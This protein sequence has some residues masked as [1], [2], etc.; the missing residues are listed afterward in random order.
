MYAND[1]TTAKKATVR[2]TAFCESKDIF[3]PNEIASSGRFIGSGFFINTDGYILTCH[4]LI[5]DAIKI[6]INTVDDG[7]KSFR[8]DIISVYP[9]ADIAVLHMKNY[10][11]KICLR[12][13][14]SDKAETESDVI[15][16]GYPLGD[17]NIKT[18]KGIISGIKDYLI[19]TD[20]TINNGNSGG[21]LL[22][23]SYEVIGVNILKRVG[24]SMNVIEGIGYCVPIKIFLTV[25]DLMMHHVSS[26][27]SKDVISYDLDNKINVIYRPNFYC[28]FQTLEKKEA[29]LM[30]HIYNKNNNSSEPIEGYIIVFIY[31][32]S[33]LA[34]CDT[35]MTVN[36]IL[37]EF[38]G[39]KI[40]RYGTIN[41]GTNMGRM[42][43][44][45]YIM[46]C[47]HDEMINI[48]FFSVKKQKIMTTHIIFKNEYCYAIPEIQ[49]PTKIKY[50]DNGG[51]IICELTTNHIAELINNS[52]I[53]FVN[54]SLL[55]KYL[56]YSNRDIPTIFISKILPSSE[57]ISFEYI[58]FCE[59]AIIQ[60]INGHEVKTIDEY[61][62]LC[63]NFIT[64]GDDKYIYIELLNMNNILMRLACPTS[65]TDI[66]N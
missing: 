54:T 57:N 36:D 61:K 2:I 63:K 37:T 24:D 55:Y 3:N 41:T 13:G 1:I 52:H 49:F 20:T 18:T 28:G 65:I 45:S 8:A 39:K 64:I 32:K 6:L 59:G 14:D 48:K 46:R 17:D 10:K 11:N 50:V 4:H 40:D 7:Q 19:Q 33:P 51:V 21:P 42:N 16:L 30:T 44:D 23:S 43:I 53:S 31:K 58:D 5:T 26:R 35:P 62:L 38:D 29:L 66:K 25:Y 27:S 15:A 34:V 56:L 60:K 12:L 47:K 22:N 9:E